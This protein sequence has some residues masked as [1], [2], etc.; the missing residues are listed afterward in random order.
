MELSP[1]LLL[2]LS[3]ASASIH[4]LQSPSTIIRLSLLVLVSII[5]G[6]LALSKCD[7]AFRVL[8][9]ASRATIANATHLYCQ[10]PHHNSILSSHLVVWSKPELIFLFSTLKYWILFLELLQSSLSSVWA[11]IRIGCFAHLG[12]YCGLTFYFSVSKWN[13]RQYLLVE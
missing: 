7:L 10:L 6:F 1:Q 13:L 8:P 3:S 11:W 12:C 2:W 5:F 4:C 9:W